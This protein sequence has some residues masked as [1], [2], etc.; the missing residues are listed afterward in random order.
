M[1]I[2]FRYRFTNNRAN[3][4]KN[5]IWLEWKD[6]FL[7]LVAIVYFIVLF[8]LLSVFVIWWF[9]KY[10]YK[11]FFLMIF[12]LFIMV[13]EKKYVFPLDLAVLQSNVVSRLPGCTSTKCII[14]FKKNCTFQNVIY[15]LLEDNNL[16]IYRPIR[17]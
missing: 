12:N 1:Q 2:I 17:S 7:S 9:S 15:N 11:C 14:M 3:Y 16:L 8:W 10:Y 13:F 5:D 6:M 4:A